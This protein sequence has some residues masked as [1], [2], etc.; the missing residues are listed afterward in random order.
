MVALRSNQRRR[1]RAGG[2]AH[3]S[4]TDVDSPA[5]EADPERGH[6]AVE[7]SALAKPTFADRASDWDGRLGVPWR[8][9]LFA[10][11]G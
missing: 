2:E 4:P 6:T 10:N 8:R 3:R 1:A 9:V 11:V 5:I 7:I